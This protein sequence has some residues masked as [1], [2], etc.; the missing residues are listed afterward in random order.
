LIFSIYILNCLIDINAISRAKV[1][2]E[3]ANGK[4]KTSPLEGSTA[5]AGRGVRCFC[6]T[7][8]CSR[9]CFIPFRYA[10][11]DGYLYRPFEQSREV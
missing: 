9:L 4:S 5:L 10:R 1:K 3:T 11:T 6:P 7:L 2:S 8:L